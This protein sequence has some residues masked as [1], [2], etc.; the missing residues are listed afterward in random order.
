MEK[1][2]KILIKK[3]SKKQEEVKDKKV[4]E[5]EI[6]EVKKEVEIIEENEDNIQQLEDNDLVEQYVENINSKEYLDYLINYKKIIEDKNKCVRNKKCSSNIVFE[7]DKV[8]Y[9]KK[10][11]KKELLLPFYIN[12]HRKLDEIKEEK[13]NVI[14][15][16][17]FYKIRLILI[18][19]LQF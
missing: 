7:K 8:T 19:I 4:K 9:L 10:F 5:E 13:L 12:I 2:R 14:S 6:E 15:K 18:L 3:E 1:K 16:L 11:D 17:D